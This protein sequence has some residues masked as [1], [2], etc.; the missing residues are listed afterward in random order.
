MILT[1]YARETLGTPFKHQGRTCGEGLDCVGVGQHIVKRANLPHT[2]STNYARTPSHNQLMIILDSQL[3]LE[4]TR[5]IEEGCFLLMKFFKQPMH[6]AYC[7]GNTIIHAYA[8]NGK[9]VEHR[10]DTKWRNRVTKIYKVI[11]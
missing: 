1:D 4:P 2:D 5:T 10:L 8:E 7:A 6:L 9:V 11:V 3:C